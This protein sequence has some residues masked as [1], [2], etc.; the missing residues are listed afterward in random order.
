M[1]QTPHLPSFF[2]LLHVE[3]I[4]STNDEA[5]RQARDGATEGLLVWADRQSLGRGRRGRPWI[6]PPGNLYFSLLLRPKCRPA[7]AAQ[8]SFAA[9]LAVG[10][11]IAPILLDRDTVRY[12]WP[13]DVMVAGRK[14]SGILLESQATADGMIEWLVVGIGVNLISFPSKTEY[15]ATSL[16]AEGAGASSP[17]A[18]LEAIAARFFDWR[19]RWTTEGFAPLREKWLA[20]AQGLGSDIRVRLDRS[21]TTG[22]FVT[23]ALDGAL[24]LEN[25]SGPQHISAGAVLPAS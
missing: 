18:L 2:R 15:P 14:I 19:G 22:R 6:S 9:A 16:V 21:E 24:V 17:E 5:T 1:K 20:L 8:L 3:D 23:L 7:V 13:N 4:D 11:T 12:K 25:S 10:E